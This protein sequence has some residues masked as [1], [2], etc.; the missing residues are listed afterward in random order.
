LQ[1]PGSHWEYNDVR[2]NQLSLALLHLF[3]QPLSEVFRERIMRPI[4]ASEQWQWVGYDHA[5]VELDGQRVQ[6]VPGGTHWGGGV[7]I[8]SADQARI[9]QLLLDEGRANGTQVLSA[10]W[11]RR[12]R[13][14][15]AIAPFYGYLVWLNQGR[16]VFPSLPESSWFAIGA[17]SSFTWI[18]PQRR[19]VL[20]VRWIDAEHADAF[21]ARVL[22]AL[23]G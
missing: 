10:A 19:M 1:A 17:G 7:S 8:G 23:D 14:P 4:G 15:C 21:F 18:E 12:M 20:V 2:I 22:R 9:G 16:R 3:G 5:W 13:T 6:S 11:T